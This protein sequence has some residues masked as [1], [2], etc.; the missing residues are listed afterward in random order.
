MAKRHWRTLGI[1]VGVA[2]AA[3]LPILIIRPEGVALCWGHSL[4]PSFRPYYYLVSSM[5][6]VGGVLWL[7]RVLNSWETDVRQ[8]PRQLGLVGS[9]V[10][11]FLGIFVG[12]TATYAPPHLRV[13]TVLA[14]GNT[15]IALSQGGQTVWIQD[16][17]SEVTHTVKGDLDNDGAQEIVVATVPSG[18]RSSKLLIFDESG[19]IIFDSDY[20]VFAHVEEVPYAIQ[21]PYQNIVIDNAGR[22]LK[23]RKPDG[24]FAKGFTQDDLWNVRRIAY[25][26]LPGGAYEVQ[27]LSVGNV[28]DSPAEEIVFAANARYPEGLHLLGKLSHKG[29]LIGS[30]WHPGSIRE[31]VLLED[32]GGNDAN[33]VVVAENPFLVEGETCDVV[34]GL[35]GELLDG[36]SCW[37]LLRADELSLS[38]E[39]QLETVPGVALCRGYHEVLR[40]YRWVSPSEVHVVEITASRRPLWRGPKLGLGATETTVDLTLSDGTY[41]GLDAEGACLY[42][43]GTGAASLEKRQE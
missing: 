18:T 23:V 9:V 19:R 12:A 24:E 36:S 16:L 30:Y 22:V 11:I 13:H 4:N 6:L 3:A 29:E 7:E 37:N 15:V 27:T 21:V 14:D 43:G 17:E 8:R 34:F 33:I 32:T 42:R 20:V 5:A 26:G 31:V 1:V 39:K 40:W 10:V 2:I 28:D 25:Y 41:F 38:Y 35:S